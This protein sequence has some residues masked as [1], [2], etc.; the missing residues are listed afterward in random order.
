MIFG[1]KDKVTADVEAKKSAAINS[2]S[3]LWASL[4]LTGT[5]LSAITS[6]MNNFNNAN[7][8]LTAM[9]SDLQNP[10]SAIFKA[11]G[12]V[13]TANLIARRAAAQLEERKVA[14]TELSAA[15]KAS[16]PVSYPTW[17]QQV[18]WYLAW[19]WRPKAIQNI[20]E[21]D[22]NNALLD[23]KFSENI[24]KGTITTTQNQ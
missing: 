21:D 24:S 13:E 6:Y 4:G 17:K 16:T 5:K 18:A 7:D 11:V 15:N 19:M 20:T 2:I 14:A 12:S 1:L 23:P 3:Q 22:F 8:A 9:M 10:S